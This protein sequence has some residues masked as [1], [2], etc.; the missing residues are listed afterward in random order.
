[1]NPLLGRFTQL[2]KNPYFIID[3]AHNPEGIRACIYTFEMLH[4]LNRNE[5]LV[6]YASSQK[7]DYIQNLT[8]LKE[9]FGNNL[10]ITEF[11][12]PMS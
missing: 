1:V 3:G 9:N 12:H 2:S 5:V 7:K 10:Y 6:L 4:N 8:L 11:Q